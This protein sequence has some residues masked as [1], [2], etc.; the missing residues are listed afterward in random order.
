MFWCSMGLLPLVALGAVVGGWTVLLVP[1]C[2]WTL[3][4]ILD[5]LLGRDND[6]AAPGG[7]TG[8]LF[9]HHLLLWL[10]PPLQL[11]AIYGAIWWV[12]RTGH[13]HGVEILGLFFGIG[14]ISGTVGLVYAHELMHRSSRAER[15]LADTL[16]ASVLYSHFR[17]EHLLVH[18]PRVGTPR[19][20]V[21]ARYGTGFYSYFLRVLTQCPWSALY[22]ERMR[23]AKSARSGWSLANPFWR[24]GLLQAA[25]LGAAWGLGRE[26]GV[27]LFV[28]QAF[29]AVWQLELTNYVEHY[30]LNRIY[31]GDGQYEPV[32]P[33]HSWNAPHRASN[34][35]MI[36]LQRHSDHH[37]HPGR[38]YPLLRDW[39]EADAPQLPMGYPAMGAVAMV[40]PLWRRRMNPRV[41]RWRR[42]H[43]PDITD[44]SA[45]DRNEM[46]MPR[47][48]MSG[49]HKRRRGWRR[50]PQS[51]DSP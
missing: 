14:V 40:P 47:G 19:D 2:A 37:Y 3:V 32:R 39:P 8:G 50:R 36:N 34:G 22:A 28:F 42:R 15:F 4:T 7:L 30:G 21:S 16:L 48:S 9:W 11:A 35:L 51:I 6:S 27:L 17:S 13:L 25:A 23:L 1:F 20:M 18:H 12:T 45:Y 38:P 43:Y 26:M 41:R 10:W 46:P 29:I 49:L 44:W 31:A 33:R 5:A 24:Y